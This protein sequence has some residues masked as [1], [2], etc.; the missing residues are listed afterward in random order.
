MRVLG[1]TG[2]CQTYLS[3]ES[4]S[5]FC[6]SP[7]GREVE[8]PELMETAFLRKATERGMFRST[9]PICTTEISKRIAAHVL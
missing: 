8:K 3:S 5:R 9:L 6:G 4:C 2:E 1:L 7:M